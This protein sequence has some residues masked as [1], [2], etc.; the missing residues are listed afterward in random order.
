MKRIYFRPCVKV[1]VIS[2]SSYLCTASGSFGIN[3]NSNDTYT[4]TFNSK[5]SGFWSDSDIPSKEEDTSK[6]IWGD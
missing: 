1:R 5:E 4:G 6:D 3:K 2:T